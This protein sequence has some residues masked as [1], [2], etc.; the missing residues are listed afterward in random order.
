MSGWDERSDA[1]YRQQVAQLRAAVPG[2]T[3]A[4]AAGT[5]ATSSTGAGNQA[6]QANQ[7]NQA[8]QAPAPSDATAQL[9]ALGISGVHTVKSNASA[10]VPAAAL[11]PSP[12]ASAAG[13]GAAGSS[14]PAE[15]SW[16]DELNEEQRAAV[17]ATEGYVC[18]HAGAGT[19]KTRTLTYRYA[20]LI[21]EYGIAPRA[22]W[23]VTFTNR[24]ALEM[25]QRVQRMCGN[26]IGNPFVT[27]FHGFCALFL[28]EEIMAVGWPKTFTISDVSDVKDMLRPL[29]AQCQIDGKKLSLKKAWEFIDGCKET[30]DYIAALI[31]PDSAELLR[32]S[33]AATEDNLKLFWRYLFA[34]RTTYS[35][36]FD[37]LILLT[38]HILKTN[39][40]VRARWQQ[41]LEYILV[42]EFQDID[43][44]QYELV[45]LLADYHHNLF[46]VGDPDQTIYSFR[47]ARVEYF[48]NFVDNHGADA[49]RLY[50]TYNYRSSAQILAAAYAV[51]SHNYDEKRRPLLAKRTDISLEHMVPVRDPNRT[52][53]HELSPEV[54][55]AL[56]DRAYY[57][58]TQAQPEN[59]ATRLPDEE[60]QQG[61]LEPPQAQVPAQI[62]AHAPQLSALL[63]KSTRAQLKNEHRLSYLGLTVKTQAA[64]AAPSKSDVGP[65]A[66]AHERHYAPYQSVQSGGN[67]Q[68]NAYWQGANNQDAWAQEAQA[69]GLTPPQASELITPSW[70]GTVASIVAPNSALG[71]APDLAPMAPLTLPSMRPAA[72]NA[73]QVEAMEPLGRAQLAAMSEVPD[74]QG[75][76]RSLKPV[77]GHA[78]SVYREA[79][80]VAKTDK[81]LAFAKVLADAAAQG[82]T[83]LAETHATGL[84]EVVAATGENVKIRRAAHFPLTGNGL[85]EAYIHMGGKVGVLIEVGCGKPETAQAEPFRQLVHDLCLQ[86]AAAAP[87]YLNET[88]VPAEEI[89]SEKEVYRAQVE[90]KPANIVE[91]I[92]RGKLKKHFAEVCLIDQP[93]VKEPKKSVTDVVKETEKATGDTIVVKRFV[94]YQ[95]GMA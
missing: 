48:N 71:A 10:A 11:I 50:L 8:N 6:P 86:A 76:V 36:D 78:G 19:G 28:R 23:C 83:D 1:T 64:L 26:A 30:K 21:S 43:R 85:V 60:P 80:F 16:L 33:E 89:E 18:L 22:V 95:L 39:E 24:A 51:I 12:G 35:L 47:G 56:N 2:I 20:Y 40:E 63:G 65:T 5:I 32:R 15:S 74:T 81:F 84:T 14:A 82:D 72:L 31:G 55:A 44:D 17:E 61:Q 93:F 4:S 34:Q 49:Q 3:I 7:A 66:A 62:Q 90:G 79:D 58:L 25:R 70:G 27:T 53:D 46:I 69:Y 45:E 37:D 52:Q 54:I 42:D 91:G 75:Y 77:I 94:R 73:P 68:V 57:S 59:L 87:R 38:L 41:R 67:A 13:S 9:A 92:L 88:E 29:Y